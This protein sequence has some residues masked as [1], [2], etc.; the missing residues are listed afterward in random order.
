[1]DLKDVLAAKGRRVVTVSARSSVADA[2]RAMHSENVGSVMVPDAE[3]CPVGIFT[4]RDVVRLYA[5]GG[6]K[7]EEH[8]LETSG[9]LADREVVSGIAFQHIEQ[10]LA[11]V[12]DR[13]ATAALDVMQRDA[14]LGDVE[15]Q[16]RRAVLP[17]VL[18]GGRDHDGAPAS[19][20]L[21]AHRKRRPSQVSKRTELGTAVPSMTTADHADP[22]TGDRRRRSW[23]GHPRTGQPALTKHNHIFNRQSRPSPATAG[24]R[25]R[26]PCRSYA[27]T[28]RAGSRMGPGFA[29]ADARA[30]G[31][32]GFFVRTET[33]LAPMGTSPMVQRM[34]L[35]PAGPTSARRLLLFR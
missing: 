20:C 14:R 35:F 18:V 25:S 17:L 19:D 1:M 32:T 10:G 15:A 8:I 7:L 24:R 23:G 28:V 5:E 3:G 2:V 27:R 34:C 21:R 6:L 16:H 33:I 9:G 4:E 22:G 12:R 29:L 26:D 11:V 13:P 31:M 30:P